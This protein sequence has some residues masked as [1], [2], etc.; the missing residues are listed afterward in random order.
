MKKTQKN[1]L[2]GF[3]VLILTLLLGAC[4]KDLEHKVNNQFIKKDGLR[5]PVI[6]LNYKV[7]TTSYYKVNGKDYDPLD[8]ATMAPNKDKHLVVMKI[9]EKG[10]VYMEIERLEVD[11]PIDI[12]HQTLPSDIPAIHKTIIDGNV[13]QNFSKSGSLLSTSTVEIPNQSKLVSYIK[14]VGQCY[15]SEILNHALTN[16]YSINLGESI[17]DFLANAMADGYTVTNIGE[18]YFT[19]RIPLSLVD[20]NLTQEAVLLFESKTNRIVGTRLYDNEVLVSTT[21]F[22]YG[23]PENPGLKAIKQTSIDK[24]P[25]G[26]LV[27]LE[28]ISKFEDVKITI[29]I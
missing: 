5:S 11:R 7:E 29:N 1:Y 17:D 15:S 12:P 22:G 27:E 26:M 10:D 4:S 9:F 3:W 20:P 6:S 19:V 13:A 21:L 25:S 16:L 14:E 24:L 2:Y 23:P 8:L 28:I 18:N